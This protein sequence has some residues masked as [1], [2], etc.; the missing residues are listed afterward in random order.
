MQGIK[1]RE[2]VGVVGRGREER[3]NGQKI[4]YSTEYYSVPITIKPRARPPVR[5]PPSNLQE[6]TIYEGDYYYYSIYS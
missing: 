5:D 6:C 3:N 1:V 4:Y 2:R